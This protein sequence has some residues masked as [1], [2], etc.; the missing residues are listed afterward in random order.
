MHFNVPGLIRNIVYY[1]RYQNIKNV[2][3]QN[4][5]IGYLN[6]AILRFIQKSITVLLLKNSS[7]KQYRGGSFAFRKYCI[8]GLKKEAKQN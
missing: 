7:V 6:A 1:V 3:M 4:I 8:N 5:A 2:L